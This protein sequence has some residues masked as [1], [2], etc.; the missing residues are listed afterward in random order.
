MMK[1]L[2]SAARL[3]VPLPLLVA[4]LTASAG[5]ITVEDAWVRAVPPSSRMSAAYMKLENHGATADRLVGASSPIAKVTETHN[6]AQH[7][8]MMQMF[9]VDGVEVPAGGSVELKPGS[10]HVMLIDL[11]E[12]PVEGRE[13]A[14]TLRFEHAG[15][16][17]LNVP[18]KAGEMKPMGGME[19][20]HDMGHEGMGH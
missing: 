13:V 2:L 14:L 6:V 4:A 18:V 11:I 1:S 19:H 7:D 3:L 20:G 15:E 17:T 12:P 8:G 16:M 5:E 10:Y 9:K